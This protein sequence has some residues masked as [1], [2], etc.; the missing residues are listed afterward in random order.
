MHE[1]AIAALAMDHADLG[2]PAW[3]D[4]ILSSETLLLGLK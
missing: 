1:Q 4:V 2:M 3:L